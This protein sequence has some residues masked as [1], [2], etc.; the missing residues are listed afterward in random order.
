MQWLPLAQPLPLETV[1][2]VTGL[3]IFSGSHIRMQPRDA[4][5]LWRALQSDEA[6]KRDDWT[7]WAGAPDFPGTD[8]VPIHRLFDARWRYRPTLE[9]SMP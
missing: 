2:R 7:A 4:E 6:L 5:S 9:L 8:E 1:R 3:T